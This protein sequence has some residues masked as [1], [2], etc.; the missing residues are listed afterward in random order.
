MLVFLHFVYR[1]RHVG[2]DFKM[3]KGCRIRKN[4]VSL[5]DHV[6]IGYNCHIAAQVTIGNW[7]MLASQVSIVGGDHVFT[8]VGTPSIW[9]GRDE[10]KEVVI[11]DDV[12]IGHGAII[13]HGVHIGEGA[14]VAAGAVVTKNV[15]PYSIVVGCP[16][17]FL[18]MRFTGEEMIEHKR[19]LEQLRQKYHMKTIDMIR[20]DK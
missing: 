13:M 18:R 2:R 12:W 19:Q 5:G 6:Y 10:N 17:K 20:G 14:I 16:A 1:F 7:V 9:A 8:A 4:S 11:E 3:S 15:L